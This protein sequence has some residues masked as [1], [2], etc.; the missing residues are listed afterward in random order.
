MSLTAAVSFCC[1]HLSTALSNFYTFPKS[2]K[3]TDIPYAGSLQVSLLKLRKSNSAASDA[4]IL[5]H[6]PTAQKQKF[7][8]LLKIRTEIKVWFIS[9]LCVVTQELVLCS[10][11]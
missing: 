3:M 9:L 7:L 11:Y 8:F 1:E 4:R 5:V 2:Y 10:Q 6:L